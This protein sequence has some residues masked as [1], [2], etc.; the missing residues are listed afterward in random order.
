MQDIR[1]KLDEALC[2]FMEQKTELINTILSSDNP[3]ET[4]RQHEDEIDEVFISLLQANMQDVQQRHDEELLKALMSVYQIA[5][6]IMSER[7]PPE[8]Q[9]INA[10][11]HGEVPR[12][13]EV[14]APRNGE[15]S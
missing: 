5:M 9:M 13:N 6:Q 4:A 3:D 1:D 12:R 15:V 8:I 7:Q 11:L 14:V 2:V 10:L